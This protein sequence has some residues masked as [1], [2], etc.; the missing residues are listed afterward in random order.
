[1]VVDD[2]SWYVVRNT[3]NVTGFIGSGNLPIPI[4]E[5]EI[6]KLQKEWAL[7]NRL[8]KLKLPWI[9]Q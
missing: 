2:D 4:D 3:P 6:G 7:R 5:T 1:M 9:R 8:T